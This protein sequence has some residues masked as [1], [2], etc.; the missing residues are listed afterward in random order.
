MSSP[1][2]A[3]GILLMACLGAWADDWAP[4]LAQAPPPPALPAPPPMARRG[5]R[6]LQGGGLLGG[7]IEEPGK[8][9]SASDAITFPTDRKA[10]SS[11][12]LAEDFIKEQSWGE[13]SRI[14]QS[15]LESKE[16]VFVEVERNGKPTRT[17]L[18]REANRLVGAMPPQGREFYE[19]QYGARARTRLNDAKVRNDPKALAEVALRYL[20]TD[21]G[22]EAT[23]LLGSHYLDRGDY[24]MASVCF[25]RLLSHEKADQLSPITLF[26]AALALRRSNQTADADRVWARFSAKADK[27]VL[28][29]SVNVPFSQFQRE[30][31]RLA[32]H[33]A[34]AAARVADWL[35]FKGD[36][37]RSAQGNGGAPFL[38]VKWAQPTA[39][40]PQTEHWLTQALKQYEE[41]QPAIP[42]FFPIATT[43]H[44]SKETLP[45]VVYRSH[46]GIHAVDL[47]SGKL[48]WESPSFGSLDKIV[49]EPNKK[50]QFDLWLPL[51]LSY[52]PNLL[53]E[54]STTGTLSADNARVY[55]VDDLVL[56]P[57]PNAQPLQQLQWGQQASFGALQDAVYHSRLQAFDLATGKLVW[58]LGGRSPDTQGEFSDCYFLGAPLPL[59]GKLYLLIEKASELRLVCLDAQKGEVNWTQP[60]AN[61]RDRLLL[62]VGRRMRGV[63]LAY[64]GGMLVCPTN[65]GAILGVD[66]LTHSLVWAHPY[67]EEQPSPEAPIMRRGMPWNGSMMNHNLN[68]DWKASAPIIQDGKVV[69]T[70]P[71]GSAVYC[72]N[73]RD[74]SELWKDSRGDDVYL[75]GVYG[76]KVV[77]VGRTSCHALRLGDGKSL[78]SVETGTPSGEG[79]ASNNTYYLPLKSGI[80]SKEPEV[81]SINLDKGIVEA[82]TR[83]RKKEVPGNLVFYDGDVL[84]Q[85]ATSIA[86]YPQLRIR[87]AQIDQ[88]LEKNPKDPVGLTDRGE[89]KLDKGDL[90]GAV[91]DLRTALSN[92]PPPDV[93]PRTRTKLFESLT[94]LFQH[95]F[96]ANEKY[97]NE[98]KELCRVPI[99]ADATADE[100]Q[101]LE[102]EEHRRQAN[103]LCLLANGRE[104]QGRL[105]DAFH[106]YVDFGSLSGN[107][108]LVSVI[109]EPAVR[110]RP[111]V[112]A[113]GRIAAMVAKASPDQRKPLEHEIGEQ[114]EKVRSGKDLEALR[115]FVQLFGSLFTVGKEARL[116]LAERLMEKEAF[117]EAELQLYQLRAQDDPQLAA[118]AVEALAR[119]MVRKELFLEAVYFYRLLD[120]DYAK[121]MIRDA[122]TGSD[123]FNEARKDKRL[124]QFFED[125]RQ[126][127]SGHIKAKDPIYGT[128]VSP[129]MLPF[130][131]EGEVLPFF[132]HNRLVLQNMSLLK[133]LDRATN[134]ERWSQ[135]LVSSG[136][137]LNN[138]TFYFQ[139]GYQDAR[140]PYHV[141]GHLIV[142]NVG[143][144]VYGFDPIDRKV[145]W[146]Q[147]LQPGTT[148]GP[149][150]PHISVD[151]NDKSLHI[152]YLDGYTQRLGHPGP[153]GASYVCLHTRD[154][155]TALDPLR[156]T[157]LW[158]KTDVLARAEVFGDAEHIY[159]V[160]MNADGSPGHGRA[161]RAHDGATVDVPAFG[162]LHQRKLRI[163]DGRLLLSEEESNGGRRYHL[164]DVPSGKD[165]WEKTFTDPAIVLHSEEPNL[166]AVVESQEG[167]VTVIDLRKR[168]Q[169]LESR[170]SHPK[171]DLDKVSEGNLLADGDCYYLTF[172]RTPDPRANVFGGPYQNVMNGIRWINV[173]GKVYAFDRANGIARWH[174]DVPNQ[175]L[176]IDQFRESPILVF[177]ARY[178]KPP[179]NPGGFNKGA[180]Q[181]VVAT[182]TIE[183][184]TGKRLFD[185]EFQNNTMQQ[186]HA[187]TVNPQEQVIE[188]ISYGMK[189][190]HYLV[191]D[192]P[193]KRSDS[194]ARPKERAGAESVGRA[195]TRDGKGPVRVFGRENEVVHGG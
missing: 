84:S 147:N 46:Y 108:E 180:F 145:L 183:K 168:Q 31:E 102:E 123:L 2:R 90:N 151:R 181:Q 72:L 163:V 85:T 18:W 188:L 104:K 172:Q 138:A 157:V 48:H 87:L 26:K 40:Q 32:D 167:R 53:F 5:V 100:R 81:C 169:L 131:P 41:R 14:L 66:L 105:A 101:R 186:F 56:P 127:W 125:A 3:F 70:P 49:E 68:S 52:N 161:L 182:M 135:S 19:L 28:V 83:S 9:G 96:N 69:F 117:L 150:P 184:R 179:L 136:N 74:G 95:E 61:V 152:R 8:N 30:I 94:D 34:L 115:R 60:L 43:V 170:L 146:Q 112:W 22:V 121:V 130:E 177:T 178:N 58:E 13:A 129:Q 91:E 59:G 27:G 149:N 113:Q 36:P 116:H 190:Q 143:Q 25:E 142:L 44:T 174:A 155:L 106:A 79:V 122:K 99:P 12:S 76:G 38:E 55:S 165:V 78:W 92:K 15:L 54:N 128:F 140:F 16:D 193:E 6:V 93:L 24:P 4:V 1:R 50:I 45:L 187:Y 20:H 42:A 153:I 148:L 107:H 144:M 134:E 63:N 189:I 175:I 97:L 111:D 77:L 194:R 158:T 39:R 37:S 88:A 82:R 71:D 65:A 132:Q 119:L 47:R 17:S 139:G 173:N 51:Y 118:R 159:V 89:L 124:E 137:P 126:T 162:K 192:G 120:R 67:R 80:P 156:G 195:R 166:L 23:N 176:L 10:K 103:F 7:V 98:Y 62:D 86:A 164:Y 185:R 110:V 35:L 64:G 191:S 73:L 160:D 141:Q 109:D 154:G 75:A 29:G 114:W 11:L 133:L 33:S 171:E 21:A 57:H